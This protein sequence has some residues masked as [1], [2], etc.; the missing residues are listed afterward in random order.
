MAKNKDF[1]Y[2]IINELGVISEGSVGWKK[3]INRV[4]W[5]GGDPKYDIRDWNENHDKMGKG[6]T[7]SESEL[8]K[9]KELL[10]VEIKF[11]DNSSL[12]L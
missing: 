7:L 10:D 8:R 9:L 3:E 2:E 4:S 11:L 5:S 1:K 6:I 12:N